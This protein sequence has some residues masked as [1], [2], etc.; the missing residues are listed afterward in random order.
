LRD[1][2]DTLEKQLEN[3]GFARV[4]RK[5]LVRRDAIVS[6]VVHEGRV[7]LQLKDGTT[8]EVSRRRAAGLRR[9]LGAKF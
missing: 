6:V 2:L 1:S 7:V 4:H 5:V 9:V 3:S 8:A